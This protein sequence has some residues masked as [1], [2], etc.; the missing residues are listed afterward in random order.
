MRRTMS[1]SG[2]PVLDRAALDPY[3]DGDPEAAREIYAQAR[4]SLAADGLAVIA[5]L[6]AGDVAALA[7]A[8]HR[9]KGAA[10]M[11]GARRLSEAAMALESP[12]RAGELEAARARGAAFGS[13]HAA[14]LAQLDAEL[15]ASPARS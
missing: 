9:I 5:A 12:A 11:I 6:E 13:E 10:R 2:I 1:E 3:T 4:R 14:L 15:G 8:A 7:Q